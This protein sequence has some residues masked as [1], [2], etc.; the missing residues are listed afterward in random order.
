MKDSNIPHGF[1]RIPIASANSPQYTHIHSGYNKTTSA[2]PV[3]RN[4]A[5][6]SVVHKPLLLAYFVPGSCS[7]ATLDREVKPEL[8]P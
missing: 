7:N 6:R 4:E 8:A 2:L 5:G 1:F 3:H